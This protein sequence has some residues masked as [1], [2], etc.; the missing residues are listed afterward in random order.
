MWV[1]RVGCTHRHRRPEYGRPAGRSGS[2]GGR[3]G[4]W[5]FAAGGA[6]DLL[7]PKSPMSG[8]IVVAEERRTQ[9]RVGSL[10]VGLIAAAL[11]WGALAFGAVYPWAYWP[12]AAVTGSIG[13]AC[14]VRSA[15]ARRAP[16]GIW[17]LAIALAFLAAAAALQL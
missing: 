12:L 16:T 10:G 2:R 9:A 13:A 8:A 5:R 1:A 7:A 6:T 4:H 11:A 17:A 14:V 15:I 3:C